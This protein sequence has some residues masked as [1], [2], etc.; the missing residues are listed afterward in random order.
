[1][2]RARL[3]LIV[4]ALALV[5]AASARALEVPAGFDVRQ[6]AVGLSV[7]TAAAI[8]P[9]GKVFVATKS[10]GLYLAE[11]GDP[12]VREI[13]DLR[14]QVNT[15]GDRGMLGL[16]LDTDFAVNRRLYLL[17]V[18]D[19]DGKDLGEP[20]TSRLT[21]VEVAPDGSVGDETVVL[22]GIPS[23]EWFHAIGTVRS[24]PDGTLY[25][26][27]GDGTVFEHERALE[28]LDPDFL[29]GKILRV[30]R[31][32]DGL[33][34]N[35]FCP[36]ETESVCSKVY[37]GGF[38]NPFRFHLR[39]GGGLV[40]GDVGDNRLEEIDLVEAG[41]MHGW[42]CFEGVYYSHR[43][44]YAESPRCAAFTDPL[45]QPFEL[46]WPL[47][48]YGR[49]FG[50][51][52][53][54]G[55]EYAG[56]AFPDAYAG[57]IFF[58]DYVSGTIHRRR[59]DGEVLPFASGWLGTQI[60]PTTDGDDLVSVE[61]VDFSP[62]SG[63][64][65]LITWSPE[66]RTPVAQ[67]TADP[68]HGLPPLEVEFSAAGSADPHG[69]PLTYTWFWGDGSP[70]GTGVQTQHTFA[71]AGRYEVWLRAEDPDGRTGW[72]RVIVPVGNAP[73]VELT[74]DTTFAPGQPV[75]VDATATD[76]E[77]G[78][79]TSLRFTWEV[80]LHHE[81]HIHEYTAGKGRHARFD[82]DPS[83]TS[84][85]YYEVRFT[86]R[87]SHGLA[88]QS[89]HFVTYREPAT[90]DP[91]AGEAGDPAGSGASALPEDRE[92]PVIT[93]RR[94]ARIVAGRVFDASEPVKVQVRVKRKAKRGAWRNARV[95]GTRWRIKLAGVRPGRSKVRIRATD[96]VGNRAAVT[97]RVRIRR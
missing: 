88:T 90:E 29:R 45:T 80:L 35:P 92:A 10:G 49:G 91:A 27:T 21:Y 37:A 63:E 2:V 15:F 84:D 46:S 40:V 70:P 30:D 43:P 51:S 58:G 39:A 52:V 9:D 85:A 42:P 93:V 78:V 71:E 13:K 20:T 89:S 69:Q 79:L 97:R 86:A 22:D 47:Y 73:V 67:A 16:A 41:E 59:P 19:P 81:T 56:D 94:R 62:G 66:D 11:P 68:G 31:E 65:N 61:I 1:M 83:H 50:G 32:G 8:A 18:H 76:V 77:D 7:P 44:T 48:T 25:V 95:R 3:Y 64:V 36:G 4:V 74:G 55:P 53:V 33:P 28:G 6:V 5:P 24:A 38:R 75:A 14:P 12:R 87:D 72:R 26:G 54:A 17:Y 60:D 34:G 23:D 96:A 57:S 82:A